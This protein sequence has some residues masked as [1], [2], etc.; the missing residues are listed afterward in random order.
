MISTQIAHIHT[1]PFVAMY[2]MVKMKYVQ[3]IIIKCIHTIYK[4]TNYIHYTIVIALF[5]PEPE[6]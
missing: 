1:N 2:T 3:N 6:V 5:E 4:V